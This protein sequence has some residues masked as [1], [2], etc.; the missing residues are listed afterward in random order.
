M[1]AI[2]KYKTLYHSFNGVL[3]DWTW[4]QR[5]SAFA[6]AP[7]FQENRLTAART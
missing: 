3:D 6:D 5:P 4:D 1:I 7:S 2:G